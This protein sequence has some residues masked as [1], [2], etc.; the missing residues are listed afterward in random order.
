MSACPG[1]AAQVKDIQAPKAH[2][3]RNQPQVFTPLHER[4][5]AWMSES[6]L[7]E[8]LGGPLEVLRWLARSLLVLGGRSIG[9]LYSYLDR[10]DSIMTGLV[11]ATGDEVSS[12]LCC[13]V[14]SCA[15]AG[16]VRCPAPVSSRSGA[17][18]GRSA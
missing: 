16:A 2:D 3:H 18:L 13:V 12:L 14:V 1:L 15:S 8:G 7:E 11:Q 5:S 9:H 6:N 17:L 4:L 10:H